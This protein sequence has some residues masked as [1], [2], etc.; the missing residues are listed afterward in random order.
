M[1]DKLVTGG[2]VLFAV[3][4]AIAAVNLIQNPEVDGDD[5]AAEYRLFGS[6]CGKLTQFEEP[7]T[8]DKSAKLEVVDFDT[9]AKGA[10]NLKIGLLVGGTEETKGF[11]VKGEGKYKLSFELRGEAPRVGVFLHFFDADGKMT[12]VETE[13][14]FAYPQEKWTRYNARFQAPKNAV[15]AALYFEFWHCENDVYGKMPF[16]VGDYILV[17]KV[18]VE[19]TD[20]GKEIWPRR[21]VVV[22]QEPTAK[23]TGFRLMGPIEKLAPN[24]T[25]GTVAAEEKGL[26]FRLAMREVKSDAPCKENGAK[27]FWHDDHIELF[28]ERLDRKEE[29]L[30]VAFCAG[31]GKWMPAGGDY[32]SWEAKVESDGSTYKADVLI[33]WALLGVASRPAS[34]TAISFNVARERVLGSDLDPKTP[35]G[36]YRGDRHWF[37]DSAWSHVR[38]DFNRREYWGTLFIDTMVPY[39]T[40]AKKALSEPEVAAKAAALPTGDA[41][42]DFQLLASLAEENRLARLSKQPFVVAQVP[43]T[44]NPAVPFLPE[45]LMNPQPLLKV[46][47]A[48]NERTALPVAIA[49]MTETFEEYR[50]SL[51]SEYGLPTA[52]DETKRPIFG[53]RSAAGDRIGREKIGLRRGVKFRDGDDEGHGARYDILSEMNGSSS[54]PIPS[55]EAGLLWIDINLKGAKPGLYRSTLIV[56]PLSSGRFISK[57]AVAGGYEVNDGSKEIPVELEVLPFV[58]PEETK[59]LL[60]GTEHQI[61]AY[62]VD[63]AA[64]YDAAMTFVTPWFF[65][66]KFNDD[67]SIRSKS[68]RSELLAR[69]KFISRLPRRGKVSRAVIADDS[70]RV[71]REVHIRQKNKNIKDLSPEFWRAYREWVQYIDETMNKAGIPD[72][73]NEV[74]DEP[75]DAKW[76]YELVKKV[77]EETRAALPKGRIAVCSGVVRYFPTLKNLVDTWTWYGACSREVFGWAKDWLAA[78]PRRVSLVY[79]CGTSMNFDLYRY[80]R[81]L[82]WMTFMVE[83]DA[84]QI[85]RLTDDWNGF[86]F[87]MATGGGLALDTGHSFQATIRLE[88][89][90]R[91]MQDVNYLRYLK[92]LAI[93]DSP[94]AVEAR[95]F[96]ENAGN[97]AVFAAPHDSTR[98]DTLRE[99]ATEHILR[100]LKAK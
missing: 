85:F 34:G 7:A 82:P 66:A 5:F 59:I 53:F 90:Y 92:T 80:F 41:T 69:L 29:C 64:R 84:V 44:V 58:L 65:D 6:K 76:D 86:D 36:N 57:K 49:N 17:D 55:K 67:G 16:K 30:H 26:R 39:V 89:L 74:F 71:F 37:E 2:C 33:P 96:L 54:L 25:A 19:S 68:P 81:L 40:A 99:K 35:K 72:Y 91:G 23:L 14:K 70:W 75:S 22:T 27:K 88:A 60:S 28:V 47:A 63:F 8:W 42:A 83:G 12:Q 20:G 50:I 51:R 87:R 3:K 79:M 52:A 77:L 94:A 73:D 10:K 4:I 18:S 13:L 93:G 48:G 95:K 56:T 32:G 9:D 1:K 21:A 98:A 45:E 78:D 100:L 46:W 38:D 61:S 43:I 62:G 24:L 31:G 15:R 97:E 11:S